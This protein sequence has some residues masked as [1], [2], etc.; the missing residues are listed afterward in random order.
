MDR[1]AASTRNITSSG[2]EIGAGKS[3]KQALIRHA[4]DPPCSPLGTKGYP[5]AEY[6]REQLCLAVLQHTSYSPANGTIGE[7]SNLRS[8]HVLKGKQQPLHVH[9]RIMLGP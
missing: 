4:S 2:A 9:T 6:I 8:H 5:Y 3:D 7:Y 1:S